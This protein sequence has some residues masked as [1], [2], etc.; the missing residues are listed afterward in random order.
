MTVTDSL[1][2]LSSLSLG[3][4]NANACCRARDR[5]ARTDVVVGF[6]RGQNDKRWRVADGEPRHDMAWEGRHHLVI[7]A[8][9][10]GNGTRTTTSRSQCCSPSLLPRVH[11]PFCKRRLHLIAFQ[12]NTPSKMHKHMSPSPTIFWH[13]G[14]GSVSNRGTYCTVP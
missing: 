7:M 1:A 9:S 11:G 6:R 4:K 8:S 10:W 3:G 2:P 12:S 5:F 14:L 13:S